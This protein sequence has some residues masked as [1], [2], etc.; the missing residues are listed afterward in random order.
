MRWIGPLL[1]TVAVLAGCGKQDDSSITLQ[2]NWKPEPQ[3][4]GFYAAQL[5]GAFEK[6]GLRNVNVQAGGVGT[7]TVQ[8]IGAGTVQFGIISADE[9]ITARASG[10]NVVALF[11]AYQTCPQG[12][13]THAA[14]GFDDIGDVFANEGTVAMQ[15]GLPYAQF[16]KRKYGFD[17][18]KIVPSPGGDISIFLADQTFSQQCFITS[19]PLAAKKA[20]ADPKT[21]LV[22]DAGYNPYTTV[23]ATS[24][25]YYKANPE[26]CKKMVNAVRDGWT[27]YLADPG[28]TNNLM[29]G[30][31][32]TM[33]EQ[34]FTDSAAAQK[35][36]IE[37]EET[38]ANG[39]GTMTRLR[40]EELGKQ[41]V[42]LGVVPQAPS[43][44]TC[45]ANP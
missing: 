28:P 34:T 2:L 27:A 29:R 30:L 45:F 9:L 33:D 14:R 44:E 13:M 17:K 37:T 35:P 8:M 21:F 25:S 10:N 7:P 4:G 19:E 22:A 36:L 38:K 41:L 23:L 11:A 18:V 12:I 6:A 40:W 1:L 5:N 32:P 24:E 43:P 42:E 16:L 39:L 15:E 31:N 26:L 20:G 3:F